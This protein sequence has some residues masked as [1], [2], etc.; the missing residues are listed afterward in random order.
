MICAKISRSPQSRYAQILA[1]R[2]DAKNNRLLSL[3]AF[4]ILGRIRQLARLPFEVGRQGGRFH[5]LRGSSS[6]NAEDDTRCVSLIY[7]KYAR[8]PDA[9][10]VLRCARRCGRLTGHTCLISVNFCVLVFGKDALHF[11]TSIGSTSSVSVVCVDYEVQ[12]RRVRCNMLHI[13]GD[14]NPL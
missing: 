11:V 2:C 10:N 9:A 5:H 8:K 7:G 1:Y 4:E 13:S 12:T 3:V 6:T 14:L